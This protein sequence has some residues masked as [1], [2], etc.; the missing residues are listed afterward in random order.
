MNNHYPY[1]DLHELNL[2]WILKKIKELKGEMETFEALNTIHYAGLWS[3][4]EQ[5]AKYDL[6]SLNDGTSYLAL[7]PVPAGID[8]SNTDYWLKV[9]DY[10]DVV[11]QIDDKLDAFMNR[12][13]IFIGDSYAQT[14]TAAGTAYPYLV[15]QMLGLTENTDFWV[16]AYGGASFKGLGGRPSFKSLLEGLEG[17]IADKDAIGL[18]VVCGGVNDAIGTISDVYQGAEAFATYAHNMYPNAKLVTGMIGWNTDKATMT[19]I[20]NVSY[21]AYNNL[22]AYGFGIIDN[23]IMAMHDYRVF[24]GDGTHPTQVGNYQIAYGIASFIT[25]GNFA[26]NGRAQEET[27]VTLNSTLF[28]SG[29]L[30]FKENKTNNMIE[31]TWTDADLAFA[32][33]A[34]LGYDALFNIGTKTPV[35][36]RCQSDASLSTVN[37]QAKLVWSDGD[38]YHSEPVML[39]ILNDDGTIRAYPCMSNKFNNI[40]NPVYLSIL[41]GNAVLLPTTC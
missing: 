33:G 13:I 8:I 12:K 35:Y 30:K 39:R 34:T 26:T 27:T 4:A 17:T 7:Q 16:N 28:S 3:I 41:A 11:E 1:T 14:T 21:A 20:R 37:A 15:G 22:G 18:I 10:S 24:Q 31:V 29:T 19:K 5:Y 36:W 40:P 32:P 23:A 25:G 9:I 2:D 6:V 38:G